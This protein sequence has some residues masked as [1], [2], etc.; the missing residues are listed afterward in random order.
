MLFSFILS[1]NI[2]LWMEI[3]LDHTKQGKYLSRVSRN[4]KMLQTC[5]CNDHAVIVNAFFVLRERKMSC[6][7]TT[8]AETRFG[9]CRMIFT[10]QLLDLLL[11]DWFD[12]TEKSRRGRTIEFLSRSQRKITN[13]FKKTFSVVDES[14]KLLW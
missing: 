3:R 6:P 7:L 14:F 4:Q 13:D 9:S 10:Q 11:V 5:W 2:N 8:S 12:H 1:K